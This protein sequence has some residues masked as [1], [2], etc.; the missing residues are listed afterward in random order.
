METQKKDAISI[1]TK[2]D[3]NVSTVIGSSKVKGFEKAFIVS[4]AIGELKDLLTP[5]YMKPIMA[6]QNN[7][8]G[9][10]TDKKEGGYPEAVVKNCLIEA[11]L[12]GVQ[13]VGNMFNIIAGNTYLTKEGFGY[14]LADARI[15]NTITFELPRIKDES[16]AVVAIVK[17][18]SNGTPKEQKLDL[19]IKVNKYM[20]ADAVI[21]KAT[22]KARAWLY[23][24][25]MGTEYGDGDIETEAVVISTKLNDTNKEEERITLM[26]NDC[27]TLEDLTGLV[28]KVPESL[29]NVYLDK[30]EALTAKQ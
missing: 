8:L 29:M 19:P 15:A 6:L 18:D 5:E 26:I 1:I 9:F 25:I 22:R 12:M 17:W 13:P 20:G 16:A 24:S 23:N 11:V 27:T 7:R 14:L 2:L 3:L 10:L 30:K 21:G 28:T 4:K